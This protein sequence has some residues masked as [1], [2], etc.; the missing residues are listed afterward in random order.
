M[1]LVVLAGVVLVVGAALA[2]VL[3]RNGLRAGAAIVTQAVACVLALPPLTSVLRTGAVLEGSWPWSYPVEIIV[4]RVDA[5]SAFFLVWSL[6][7]TLLGTVYAVG[8]LRPYFE[9]GRNGGPQFALLNM[10]SLAFLM[11]YSVQNALVFLLGWEIA[12]IAAWLPAVL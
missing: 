1:L 9:A 6:P 2:L 8:Y 5:L 4:L 10:T 3:P 11:V 12:A 7:L